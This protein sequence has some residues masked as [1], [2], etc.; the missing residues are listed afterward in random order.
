MCLAWCSETVLIRVDCDVRCIPTVSHCLCMYIPVFRKS[1][2][3][4]V[5]ESLELEPLVPSDSSS[6]HDNEEIGMVVHSNETY[7]VTEQDDSGCGSEENTSG[8]SSDSVH[9]GKQAPL[10]LEDCSTQSV[11]VSTSR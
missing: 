6:V 9:V 3:V 4:N 1:K 2:T 8:S 5:D 10:S 11:N 7:G